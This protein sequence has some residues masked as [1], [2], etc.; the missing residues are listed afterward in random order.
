M[1]LALRDTTALRSICTVTLQ[2]EMM[3]VS[4]SKEPLRLAQ[5]LSC[6]PE[7]ARH[8]VTGISSEERVREELDAKYIN[9]GVT[10]LRTMRNLI[11]AELPAGMA[12]NKFGALIRTAINSLKAVGAEEVLF[13]CCF[14]VDIL[15]NKTEDST[16]D[17]RFHYQVTHPDTTKG[18]AFR[19]WIS[20]EAK[21]AVKYRHSILAAMHG[22]A[23]QDRTN[24]VRT[25]EL[26]KVS[27][28]SIKAAPRQRKCPAC[29]RRHNFINSQGR[30]RP[31]TR[32]TDCLFAFNQMTEGD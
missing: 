6:L 20:Q 5:L 24:S 2:K 19:E 31:C 22:S 1:K 32:F 15:T 21:V 18:E 13:L 25:N 16:H 26:R 28:I 10:I 23:Q 4:G 30:I 17:R 12:Y 27:A 7:E 29:S 14:T 11:Q 3:R 8:L 9:R